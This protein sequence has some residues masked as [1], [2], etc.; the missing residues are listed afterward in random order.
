MV[1]ATVTE[2]SSTSRA[3]AIRSTRRSSEASSDRRLLR[4]DHGAHLRR[5]EPPGGP[6]LRR[7]RPEDPLCQVISR[8][9]PSSISSPPVDEIPRRR[10]RRRQG[11]GQALE[12]LAR[13]VDGRSPPADVLDLCGPHR[14][15]RDRRPLPRL[16]HADAAEQRLPAREQ[17]RRPGRRTPARLHPAGLRH[18]LADHPRHVDL[19]V[20]RPHRVV[21]RGPPRHHLRCAR[22]GSSADGSTPC[23][24]GSETS[25]SRSPPTSS[26]PWSSCRRCRRGSASSRTCG[27]SRSRSAS[28]RGLR[29]RACCAPRSCG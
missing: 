21:P 1:G 14:P 19:A 24:R 27:S 7:S 11:R 6:P 28:S 5:G 4:D 17:Q 23:S 13:R 29:Q 18:L 22:G 26:P 25:S 12:P 2:A 9:Q 15:R 10:D 20:G 3:S 16:V 8:A